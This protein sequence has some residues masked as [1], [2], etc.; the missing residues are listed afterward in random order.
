M[1]ENIDSELLISVSPVCYLI[2]NCKKY[3]G[4]VSNRIGIVRTIDRAVKFIFINVKNSHVSSIHTGRIYYPAVLQNSGKM[5]YVYSTKMDGNEFSLIDSNEK[6]G[7][8]MLYTHVENCASFYIHSVDGNHIPIWS[9]SQSFVSVTDTTGE[10]V[11][12]TDCTS[13]CKGK[14]CNESDGCGAPCECGNGK[15]CTSKGEC[16]SKEPKIQKCVGSQ[17]QCQGK[18]HG[19]CPNGLF[20]VRDK[21]H[22]HSCI[23]GDRMT[24]NYIS[25]LVWLLVAVIFIIVVVLVF[26]KLLSR[27][28]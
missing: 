19:I 14:K 1:S 20:C 25:L 15:I 4:I 7:R 17:I 8:L 27:S 12:I 2:G 23:G 28:I 3:L 26:W 13:N 21:T 10:D 22:I 5:Q 24:N 18:C 16:I 9:S 6:Q 11:N